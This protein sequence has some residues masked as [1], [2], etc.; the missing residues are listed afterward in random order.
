[1]STTE[2]VVDAVI[3]GGMGALTNLTGSAVN[4]T[5]LDSMTNVA[6]NSIK[7]VFSKNTRKSLKKVARRSFKCSRGATMRLKGILSKAGYAVLLIILIGGGAWCIW[8]GMDIRLCTVDSIVE[9]TII[10][11]EVWGQNNGLRGGDSYWILSS[12][13]ELFSIE[14][15]FYELCIE[16]NIETDANLSVEI[17]YNSNIFNRQ[18]GVKHVPIIVGMQNGTQV[19]FDFDD[20]NQIRTKNKTLAI[21]IGTV[22]LLLGLLFSPLTLFI[23]DGMIHFSRP[24]KSSKNKRKTNAK[25]SIFKRFF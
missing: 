22:P 19:L 15:R 17:D 7:T 1:M 12:D 18:F 6:K 20:E 4:V 14:Q 24:L 10:I 8:Y 5:K 13:G 3:S 11:Q 23:V 9:K 25:T 16:N 2:K 21:L